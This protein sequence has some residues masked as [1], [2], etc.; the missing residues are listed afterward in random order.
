[1]YLDIFEQVSSATTS[2]TTVHLLRFISV[3]GLSHTFVTVC[4]AFGAVR[5][6][7]QLL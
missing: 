2:S 7:Q 6:Y 3:F 5:N 1:M 4:Q